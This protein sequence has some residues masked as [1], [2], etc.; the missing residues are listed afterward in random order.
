MF[1][2]V[3]CEGTRVDGPTLTATVTVRWTVYGEEQRLAD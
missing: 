3:L 1:P 2:L